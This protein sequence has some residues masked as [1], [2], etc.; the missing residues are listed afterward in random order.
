M[1]RRRTFSPADRWRPDGSG[2][3]CGYQFRRKECAGKG[4]HYCE[5]RA[6]RVVAFFTELLVHTKG[7]HAR[8]AFVPSVWQQRDILGP[9]FG[10]VI[11]SDEYARYVRRYT[12]GY[13]VLGRK[14]GKSE[15]AAG[16][17]LYLTVGDDEE[18]AEVYG[19]AKDTKQAGKV[20]EPAERM[21]QLSPVLSQRL[22]HNK[23]SRRIFDE[24]T[25]SY[26]EV[27][28]ADAQGELGHN[29]HGF[30]LDEVLSQR[31]GSLWTAMRTAAGARTQPLFLAITTETNDARSFG[32]S[33][34]DEAE[35]IQ[36]NPARAPHVFAYVRKLPK[37]EDELQRLRELFPG[38]PDL[39]V[40]CD[41]FDEANW[42]WPNPGLD[43]FLSRKSLRDE[44]LEAVNEPEK[45]NGFR[46]F[47]LNQ[48]MTQV[49][50]WMPMH[51][52]RASV[53]DVWP[54]PQWG[55][56]RLL[57][58][59]C[60]AGFDLSAKFDLTAW[61]LV[62]PFVDGAV[63]GVDVMWRFWL[64]ES[65]LES[66]DKANDGAVSAWA[67]Q[68]WVTVTEGEVIDYEVV[69]DDIAAD[70][71]DFAVASAD[72]DQWSMWPVIQ[73]I[74]KRLGWRDDDDRI[75]A[76]SNTYERMTP[77]MT[78]L[79]GLVKAGGFRSHGN[80]V[81][82]W[83]FDN[84]EVRHQRENPELIRPDKPQRDSSGLRID[85]VPSAA[86][87]LNAWKSGRGQTKKKRGR[88]VG[89]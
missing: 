81:A 88:V 5:P 29:P 80:P 18:A 56:K 37:T 74:G 35:R 6:D 83:C 27:I 9:L 72:C 32:A 79:M 51:R 17:V 2:P 8:K 28:T 19:A 43:E 1:A 53:G 4:P 38:H 3:V 59:P 21:R 76:Y 10:E 63:A 60:W 14:N 84:V 22:G 54:N 45:E 33:L 87:A 44:A 65:A 20:F 7:A 31:D 26:Y 67:K 11:W 75:L 66:L 24:R 85:A 55:R 41:A 15:T 25:A 77:G 50:R 71:R 70:G 12:V 42:K 23:N 73:Q 40:S 57:G 89:Y 78:E 69:Y 62:F 61:C 82:E 39:P 36:E 68:G 30:V 58:R 13:I 34:I 16:T 47:R 64:P 86:M 52:Y 48:R 46:Q 49:S